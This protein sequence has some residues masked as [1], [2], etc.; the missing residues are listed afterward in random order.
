MPLFWK[1]LP[2]YR[3]F[4]VNRPIPKLPFAT[5]LTN[6]EPPPL[7]PLEPLLFATEAVMVD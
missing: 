1:L 2:P 3:S 7:N 6:T 4:V 5:L